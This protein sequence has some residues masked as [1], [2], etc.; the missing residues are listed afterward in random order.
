MG[1]GDATWVYSVFDALRASYLQRDTKT[2][3]LG[4]DK[5]EDLHQS[6]TGA[7]SFLAA[8][9]KGFGL[10]CRSV[11]GRIKGVMAGSCNYGLTRSIGLTIEG[12]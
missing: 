5:S 1:G 9:I 8:I 7:W 3:R 4:T 6:S 11:S 10:A 12:V 2:Q